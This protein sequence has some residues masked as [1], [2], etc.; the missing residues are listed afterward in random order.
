MNVKYLPCLK[1]VNSNFKLITSTGRKE[2]ADRGFEA[3]NYWNYTIK[4]SN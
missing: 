2:I 4:K 1:V 3:V